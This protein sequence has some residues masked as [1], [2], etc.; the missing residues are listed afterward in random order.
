MSEPTSPQTRGWNVMKWSAAGLALSLV[1]VSAL[2]FATV[3]TG[4]TSR[5]LSQG[6][7][8]VHL[9]PADFSANI[10]NP[11]W[12]MRVGSRWVYRVVDSS[13]L[14]VQHEVIRVTDHTKLI[15]DGIE[16]RVVH[17][18]VTDHGD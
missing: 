7:D 18:V 6:D 9:K 8:P 10:D 5:G 2:S 16:A 4:S 14:S 12:P 17:D 3:A 13:D 1:A 11:Q 15:A